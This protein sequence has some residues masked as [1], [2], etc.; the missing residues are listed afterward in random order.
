MGGV[1]TLSSC[2][3]HQSGQGPHSA[4][5]EVGACA[6]LASARSVLSRRGVN[7]WPRPA[8][9]LSLLPFS[10]RQ[11]TGEGQDGQDGLVPSKGTSTG[12]SASTEAQ[13][14]SSSRCTMAGLDRSRPP[15]ESH[16]RLFKSRRLVSDKGQAV[17]AV[18]RHQGAHRK[19]IKRPGQVSWE[20][21]AL[22]ESTKRPSTCKSLQERYFKPSPQ[23]LVFR[24]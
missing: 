12:A 23:P 11:L 9:S 1:Q 19:L 14:K 10:T 4:Q 18:G 16:P 21:E 6:Q 2:N 22:L 17:M 20:Y 5:A 3:L 7:G 15:L 8:P 13:Q 24:F